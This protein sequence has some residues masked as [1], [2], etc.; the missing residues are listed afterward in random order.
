[1]HQ[2]FSHP[3][4]FDTLAAHF[5]YD[6][7]CTEQSLQSSHLKLVF[8]KLIIHPEQVWHCLLDVGTRA[9]YQMHHTELLTVDPLIRPAEATLE[10]NQCIT[11]FVVNQAEDRWRMLQ[12]GLSK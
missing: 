10:G 1:M 11:N 6:Y 7:W 4:L 5:Q 9:V 12:V 3:F 2:H 8:E